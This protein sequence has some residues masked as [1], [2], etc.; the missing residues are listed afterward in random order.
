MHVLSRS[1]VSDPCDPID[2]T[3]PGFSV[4]GILQAR[5]LEWDV[6]SFSRGSSQPRNRSQV[7]CIAGKLYRLS[8][9][10][11]HVYVWLSPFAVHLKL[12]HVVNWLSMH[13]C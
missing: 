6:I 3:P 1:V 12:P 13:A 4:H 7:S 8:Y 11:V 9:K 2:C 5:I 10:W